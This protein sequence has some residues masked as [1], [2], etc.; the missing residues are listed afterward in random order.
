[1]TDVPATRTPFTADELVGALRFAWHA[2]LGGAPTRET[3][4]VL[5]AQIAFET[6]N[7]TE[8]VCWN[9]GNFKWYSGAPAACMFGTTEWVGSP[10]HRIQM[11]GSFAAYPDLATGIG[12]YL[13]ALYTRWTTAWHSVVAGDPDGFARGLK[14]QGYYTAPVEQYV[15]GVRHW[16]AFYVAR[17]GGDADKT[18]P[19]V[20]HIPSIA[21]IAPDVVAN[22]PNTDDDPQRSA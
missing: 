21:P 5:A 10:P 3:L 13:H 4:A 9:I 11:R 14:A 12:A 6:A 17:L 22:A 20:P 2:Q 1:M 19:E 15:A 18:L 16:F 7:G 8:C